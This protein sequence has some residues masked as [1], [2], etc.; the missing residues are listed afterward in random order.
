VI[1]PIANA[2]ALLANNT[3][4][5]PYRPEKMSATRQ[6][7]R[8][9]SARHRPPPTDRSVRVCP[10]GGKG[11]V[12]SLVLPT[13]TPC[14]IQYHPLPGHEIQG[15]ETTSRFVNSPNCGEQEQVWKGKKTNQ[16]TIMSARQHCVSFLGRQEPTPFA[17]AF[18]VCKSSA[19]VAAATG[20]PPA[21]CKSSSAETAAFFQ[22]RETGFSW[23]GSG[24]PPVEKTAPRVLVRARQPLERRLHAQRGMDGPNQLNSAKAHSTSSPP[25]TPLLPLPL[26]HQPPPQPA[27]Q[28]PTWAS[29]S[30]AAPPI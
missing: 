30:S 29:Q 1:T 15:K 19:P 22:R 27:A 12:P 26:P 17:A 16:P 23:Y 10:N 24:P 7:A 9:D 14:W 4:F 2:N 6:N 28:S 21:T 13:I 3:L 8:R 5:F 11:L 20:W 25:R 18:V